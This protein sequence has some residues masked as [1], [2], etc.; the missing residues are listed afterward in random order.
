MV[1]IWAF[2]S[3]CF[4]AEVRRRS[5]A[6]RLWE[7][8]RHPGQKV[9]LGVFSGATRILAW[10]NSGEEWGW[11]VCEGSLND[12]FLEASG[13][14]SFLPTWLSNSVRL[15]GRPRGLAR[16]LTF[17]ASLWHRLEYRRRWFL[18][19]VDTWVSFLETAPRTILP[20][21]PA[22]I[23][24]LEKKSWLWD[25]CYFHWVSHN[26]YPWPS[27]FRYVP[28]KWR[29]DCASKPWDSLSYHSFS[30][31]SRALIVMETLAI[32]GA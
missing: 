27:K 13:F 16:V 10:N 11:I 19:G 24:I 31:P 3:T 25:F 1:L 20:P 17:F 18:C 7:S 21:V 6:P 9:H 15:G 26:C 12:T 23:W 5:W 30:G 28:S 8:W 14:C 2:C 29:W 22:L 4:Y 32:L